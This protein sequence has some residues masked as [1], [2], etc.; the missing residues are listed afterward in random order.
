MGSMVDNRYPTVTTFRNPWITVVSCYLAITPV[1]FSHAPNLI[2][3][4]KSREQEPG[5]RRGG[6]VEISLLPA[7][8]RWQGEISE[9]SSI[10][11]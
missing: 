9:K 7:I 6:T 5:G 8:F 3:R 1:W 2:G 4:R 11:E 10:G